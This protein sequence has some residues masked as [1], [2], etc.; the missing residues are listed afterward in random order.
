MTEFSPGCPPD[1]SAV[2]V[3]ALEGAAS[4]LEDSSRQLREMSRRLTQQA[5][6]PGE[7]QADDDVLDLQGAAVGALQVLAD[8]LDESSAALRLAAVR[9]RSGEERITLSLRHP[10][11]DR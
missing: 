9:Y 6:D 5:A 1:R 2:D 4:D 11:R 3:Q 7:P 10:E 8:G